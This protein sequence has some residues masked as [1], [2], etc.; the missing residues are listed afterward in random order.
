MC[1]TLGG[2][3]EYRTGSTVLVAFEAVRDLFTETFLLSVLLIDV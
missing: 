1:T 2:G 3:G